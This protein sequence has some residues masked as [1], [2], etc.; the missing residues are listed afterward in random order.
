MNWILD[1]F[2]V[3]EINCEWIEELE[4]ITFLA[5]LSVRKSFSERHSA[6]QIRYVPYYFELELRNRVLFYFEIDDVKMT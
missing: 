3:F 2:T 1:L 4:F 5:K 6:I